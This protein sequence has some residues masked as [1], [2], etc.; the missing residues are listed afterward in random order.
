IHMN[1]R[2]Y[3][4][5]TGRFM[6]ADPF[7]QA[8][9]NIQSYNAYSYVLN[10]PLSR[11]D[12]SGYISLN[13]FKKITRNLIR[14]AVKIFGAELTSIAGNVASIFCGPAVAACAG[15]WNYEFTR[16]MGGSSSQA[17]KAGAIA[18]VTAQAFLE[19]GGHFN[20]LG[21]YN[22]LHLNRE[23]LTKFGGNLLTSGQIAA[24]ITAHAVVGGI[25]SVLSGG[26]FGHGFLSAGITKGAGGAFL[27]GGA[28]LSAIQIAKGT[29]VSSIIGG[30][31]SAI[32]GGKFANGARTG[33]MQFLLNQAG[34]S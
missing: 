16:A 31:V 2:V 24:Q 5:D 13:P 34:E 26:K 18:A 9:S 28:G 27:P 15:A 20:K 7:V 19:I 8:P 33:A 11:I 22:A 12:P 4:A 1:G 32:T 29:V 6:Q 25:S 17:F 23:L 21:K 3:D 30:T 10:N 14:G